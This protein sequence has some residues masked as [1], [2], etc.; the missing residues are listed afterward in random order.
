M[1]NEEITDTASVYLRETGEWNIDPDDYEAIDDEVGRF[2]ETRQD[3]WVYTHT[4]AG[5]DLRFL[6]SEVVTLSRTTRDTRRRSRERAAA[7]TRE[8]KDDMP[9]DWDN[10]SLVNSA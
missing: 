2:L 3:G 5:G 7:Y 9:P 10:D 4:V 8:Q 6:R 1:S